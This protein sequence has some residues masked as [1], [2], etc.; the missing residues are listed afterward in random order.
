MP[1]SSTID[2]VGVESVVMKTLS[3]EKMQVTV[4]LTG[5]MKLPPYMILNQKTA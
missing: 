5:S 2:D 1:S 3:N 4:M